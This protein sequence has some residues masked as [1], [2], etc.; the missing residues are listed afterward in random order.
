MSVESFSREPIRAKS[1]WA[2]FSL[3][4][5]SGSTAGAGSHA[6]AAAGGWNIGLRRG[7]ASRPLR[8]LSLGRRRHRGALPDGSGAATVRL[9]APEREFSRSFRFIG[10]PP[11]L[12]LSCASGYAS[13]AMRMTTERIAFA[14]GSRTS[15]WMRGTPRLLASSTADDRG[16]STSMGA[17]MMCSAS[18][19]V[20]PLS[21]S[22]WF[23]TMCRLPGIS[24]IVVSSSNSVRIARRLGTPMLVTNTASVTCSSATSVC[25][26]RPGRRVHDDVAEGPPQPLDQ[27]TERCRGDGVA[28]FGRRRARD[29]EE[30]VVVVGQA[31]S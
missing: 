13:G 10:S 5:A 3:T 21:L 31:R 11:S 27:P 22:V 14:A 28:Q 2:A 16:T 1:S 7:A 15:S 18:R 8:R 17:P 30:P 25:S 19:T 26:P 6:G 20:S 23:S 9:R 24:P 29:D 4:A 12:D